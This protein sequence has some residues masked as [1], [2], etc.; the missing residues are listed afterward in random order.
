MQLDVLSKTNM[1]KKTNNNKNPYQYFTIK[2]NHQRKACLSF[3]KRIVLTNEKMKVI[4]DH[5]SWTT[6]SKGHKAKNILQW[7][8]NSL[9]LNREGE[10]VTKLVSTD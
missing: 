6:M 8:F 5:N 2:G 10:T 3:Q 9:I 7:K 1:L 4:C